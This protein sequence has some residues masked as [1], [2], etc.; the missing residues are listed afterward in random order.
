MVSGYLYFDQWWAIVAGPVWRPA[1]GVVGVAGPW[2]AAARAR[3]AAARSGAGGVCALARDTESAERLYR[4]PKGFDLTA[5]TSWTGPRPSQTSHP[6][7]LRS[8]ELALAC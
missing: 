6:P 4:R 1:S 3:E 8:R 7:L 5:T 2:A